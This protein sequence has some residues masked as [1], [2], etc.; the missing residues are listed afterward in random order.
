MLLRLALSLAHGAATEHKR[1]PHWKAF[2][3]KW[4]E[5]HPKCAVCGTR[6]L[7]EA[8]HVSP[9]EHEP[10][11]ELDWDNLVT[12]CHLKGHHLLI[13]HG[14]SFQQ[15]VPRVKELSRQVR[16]GLKTVAEVVAVARR[17]RVPIRTAA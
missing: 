9:F 6:W 7:L 12:L 11:R 3:K 14:G 8:H 15:Y 1:S 5:A 13:G 10:G 16:A 17:E 4:L 2:R